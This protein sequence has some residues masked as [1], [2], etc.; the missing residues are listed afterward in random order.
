M[1]KKGEVWKVSRMWGGHTMSK[2]SNLDAEL[3][4]AGIDP[5]EVD[6][7]AALASI[8]LEMAMLIR[9]PN[10]TEQEFMKRCLMT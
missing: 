3:R 8:G 2:M 9:K 6:L 10:E 7:G 5:E 4:E 1:K